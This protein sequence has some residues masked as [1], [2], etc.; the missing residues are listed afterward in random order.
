MDVPD[1]MALDVAWVRRLAGRLVN[2]AHTADDLAQ[3]ACVAALRAPGAAPESWPAWIAS[4][5]RNLVRSHRRAASRR[6]RREAAVARPLE[7]TAEH[8]ALERLEVHG[9]LLEAVRGLE[10]PY[11]TTIVAR[12]FEEVPPREIARRTGVPVR[13]VH[14]RLHRGLAQLRAHLDRRCGARG[15]WLAA[16][17]P[18][19]AVPADALAGAAWLGAKAKAAVAGATLAC[20]ALGIYFLR[21]GPDAGPL[22]GDRSVADEMRAQPGDDLGAPRPQ[23]RRPVAAAAAPPP[24]AAGETAPTFRIE[25]LVLDD[26]GRPVTGV[27]VVV[28]DLEGQPLPG[29]AV[30]TSGADGG[31]ALRRPKTY[32]AR[33]RAED[34]RYGTVLEPHLYT[35]TESHED[36]TVVVARRVALHGI[37]TDMS[38]APIAEAAVTLTVAHGLRAR[39]ARVLDRNVAVTLTTRSGADGRFRFDGVPCVEGSTLVAS[40]EGWNSWGD[41]AAAG[42]ENRVRLWRVGGNGETLEGRVVH[43]GGEPA[44][45]ATV[46]LGTASVQS[47][48]QGR[49]RLA[50]DRVNGDGRGLELTAV[51]PGFQ[52]A[53]LR[54]EASDGRR[55]DAWP[56]ELTLALGGP[57]LSIRGT[58]VRADGSPVAD[59]EVTV[60]DGHG[61]SA[62]G[63]GLEEGVQDQVPAEAAGSA[64]PGAV[65]APA[66]GRFEVAGLDAGEVRLAV[67]DPATLQRMVSEPI[68]AGARDVVLRMPDAGV[69]PHL[70]VLVLD[71]R[72]NPVAG[73]HW[74]VERDPVP[75]A[76]AAPESIPWGRSDAAGRIERRALSRALGSLLVKA[77][78]M[79]EFERFPLAEV[80]RTAEFRAVVPVP[81]AAQIQ[82]ADP[83]EAVDAV[84]FVDARG[85]RVPVVLTHGN[86]AW[87]TRRL[88]LMLGRSEAFTAHDDCV[89]L[90]L[91]RS[92][93]EVRR[94]PVTLVPG[95]LNVLRP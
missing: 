77:P 88:H 44:S 72:G 9:L 82:L 86:Q 19:A 93:G 15:A 23:E 22:A 50:L 5:L 73:A 47:D 6:G 31:F 74:T 64:D 81:V 80:A 68:P 76:D 34:A 91:L 49:F 90:V 53:R 33:V 10:E 54:C 14:T 46:R 56:A 32:G 36:L 66:I 41:T 1:E 24:A 84:E 71:R 2:D 61:S 85:R 65:A 63:A 60:A 43:L 89:E 28:C 3:D 69:W 12:Y 45:G 75:G 55:R 58:V 4:V 38:G 29:V 37:V 52:R 27:P 25:G 18:V 20:V 79:A 67:T 40:K 7:C 30:T 87:G 57:S 92:G 26:E 39:L 83:G 13:T 70:R 48:A 62:G 94:A 59:P 21:P 51:K 11:R 8:A 78:G 42:S 17:A 95:R 16:F 35:E